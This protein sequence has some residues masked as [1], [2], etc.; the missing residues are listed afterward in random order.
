[1]LA[2][3]LANVT[4]HYVTVKDVEG[5]LKLPALTLTITPTARNRTLIY[6][7]N[8]RPIRS[9]EDVLPK[10]RLINTFRVNFQNKNKIQIFG[11]E[12]REKAII[13]VKTTGDESMYIISYRVCYY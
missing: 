10:I 9:F 8:Y 2:P 7:V 12:A 6:V 4:V 5:P 1:M 11:G 3:L 13:V